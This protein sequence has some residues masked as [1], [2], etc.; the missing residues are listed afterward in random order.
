MKEEQVRRM[1]LRQF[2]T[3]NIIVASAVLGT[4]AAVYIYTIRVTKQEHFLD[5]EFEKRKGQGS[6]S[7]T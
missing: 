1:T 5:E 7:K 4:M 2:R 3:R 6:T